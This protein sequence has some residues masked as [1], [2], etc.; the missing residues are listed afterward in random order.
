MT[1]VYNMPLGVVTSF[2]HSVV[3]RTWYTDVVSI[4]GVWSGVSRH[5]P[6]EQF[7]THQDEG[8]DDGGRDDDLVTDAVNAVVVPDLQFL[9]DHDGR[10]HE[11][12]I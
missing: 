6:R 12:C 8:G 1:L 10:D 5:C 4:G 3:L 11:S 9:P 7:V 2:V